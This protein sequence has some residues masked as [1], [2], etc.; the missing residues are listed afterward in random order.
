[1]AKVNVWHKKVEEMPNSA[2]QIPAGARVHS[3]SG[4]EDAAVDGSAVLASNFDKV[5][6]IYET[7]L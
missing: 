7:R 2:T 1:M 5:R 4:A 3:S 6:I